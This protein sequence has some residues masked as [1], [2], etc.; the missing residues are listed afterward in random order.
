[1]FDDIVNLILYH[2]FCFL[3]FTRLKLVQGKKQD[4]MPDSSKPSSSDKDNDITAQF[5][6]QDDED[7]VF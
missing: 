5:D 6:A 4:D 3:D 2:C 1:M 7:V